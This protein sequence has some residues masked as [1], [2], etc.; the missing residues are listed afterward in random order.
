MKVF[1]L[2]IVF[3]FALVSSA[4]HEPPQYAASAVP[5]QSKGPAP[6]GSATS[7]ALLKEKVTL[8]EQMLNGT[9]EIDKIQS[10]VALANEIDKKELATLSADDQKALL[11]RDLF[12][13]IPAG[14][15][16]E[17]PLTDPQQKAMIIAQL[18]FDERRFIEAGHQLSRLLDTSPQYP[19]A[20]NL[21]ARCFFFLGN[22]DRTVKELSFVLKQKETNETE[23]LD[24]LFTRRRCFRVSNP[25]EGQSRKGIAAWDTYVKKAPKSPQIPTVNKGLAIMRQALE[26]PEGGN[27]GSRLAQLPENATAAEKLKRNHSISLMPPL[28]RRHRKNC[29]KPLRL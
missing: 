12:Q 27:A 7:N 16:A 23:M 20:R 26:A 5:E 14:V 9:I 10:A 4:C 29:K 17:K 18:Y 13:R 25:L 2:A 1:P 6:M 11:V 19:G 28:P 22:Q 21:L 3:G 15:S 24:A 8:L